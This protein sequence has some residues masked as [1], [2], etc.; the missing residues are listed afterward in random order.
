M[1]D[2]RKLKQSVDSGWPRV[3]AVKMTKCTGNIFERQK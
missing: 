2:I 1:E 3:E